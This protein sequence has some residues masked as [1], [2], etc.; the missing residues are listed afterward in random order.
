MI[1]ERWINRTKLIAEA[2]STV[3]VSKVIKDVIKNN[4][5]V[6]T[7]TDSY[8]VWLGSIILSGLI[9]E[10]AWNSIDKRIDGAVEFVNK[11]EEAVD[12]VKETQEDK[13]KLNENNESQ[14]PE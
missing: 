8:R 10:A 5:I 2:F 14:S 1:S 11:I 6:E 9:N 4:T 12:E 7:R 13:E 3:A